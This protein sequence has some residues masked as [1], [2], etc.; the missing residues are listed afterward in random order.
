VLRHDF[1]RHSPDSWVV[2]CDFS[3]SSRRTATKFGR[4]QP[5][6]QPNRRGSPLPRAELVALPLSR[7]N[8]AVVGCRIRSRR[9]V[10]RA[11]S[12]C[13]MIGE[14]LLPYS[15]GDG[16]LSADFQTFPPSPRNGEVRPFPDI[17]RC[18]MKPRYLQRLDLP[19]NAGLKRATSC[20]TLRADEGGGP[21]FRA[22]DLRLDRR[23]ADRRRRKC[24][25]SRASLQR[26]S[27][28]WR[29]CSQ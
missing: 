6:W 21:E 20:S 4:N 7:R 10:R 2:G 9:L 26:R 11:A 15:P 3:V 25:Y 17:R 14:E 23:Q 24:A 8:S 28:R 27:K 5:R 29:G 22:L 19:E 1:N 12:A 13:G 18:G 16:P